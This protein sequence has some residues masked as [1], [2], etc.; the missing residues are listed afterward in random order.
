MGFKNNFRHDFNS[1]SKL[2]REVVWP[3]VRGACGGG[4]LIS[5]EESGSDSVS[6]RLLDTLSGIDGLQVYTNGLRAIGSRIQQQNPPF[7]TFTVRESRTS[8]ATTEY[9]KLKKAVDGG[10]STHM[11]PHIMIHA[12]VKEDPSGSVRLLCA[13][14]S[15]MVDVLRAIDERKNPIRSTTNASFRYVEWEWMAD[16]G[17]DIRIIRPGKLTTNKKRQEKPGGFGFI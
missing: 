5:T 11:H 15:P 3:A 8:G 4:E 14:I 7:E 16:N 13:G 6:A 2:F 1:S 9:E 10:S 12:Y 17:F